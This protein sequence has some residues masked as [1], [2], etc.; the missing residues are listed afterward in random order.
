MRRYAPVFVLAV[1]ATFIGEVLFGAT[2]VSRL[3]GLIA[4]TPLYGGGA[5]LIRELARRRGNGWGRIGLLAAAYAIVEEGLAL[6]SMFNPNLFN[7]GLVGGTALGVNW[8][9]VEW[10]IGYHI[11]WSIT[12][13][14]MLTELLFPARR[15]E[16]WLGRTGLGV[17]G[18]VYAIGAVAL[19]AI[20]R[21]VIAPDF[22]APAF[23]LIGAG[24]V[25][26]GLAALALCWPVSQA[27]P[28]PA[29]SARSALSPWLVGLLAFVI[30]GAWFALLDLPHVFRS[31]P[32][33]LV[34]ILAE[35]AL[36]AGFVALIRRWSGPDHA[37]T[38]LHRLALACGAL[39]ASMLVGFFF[40]T[41]GNPID[42][43]GQGIASIATIALLALF[44]WR[45]HRRDRGAVRARQPVLN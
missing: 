37:W 26:A 16:P 45:L 10:T 7:A 40:V 19:A 25:A 9:W 5:V 38:D 34:P 24:L 36:A 4:V 14:I 12:I 18:I 39:L 11:V 23:L 17:A 21:L 44:A 8:V 22:R 3:G 32:L 20:F 27:A 42:Q 33:V 1:F 43:L 30:A 6:Q 41:A 15:A 35:L 13:P 29:S 31:S 28:T 2:P